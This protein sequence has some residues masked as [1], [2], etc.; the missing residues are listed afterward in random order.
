MTTLSRLAELGM[1]PQAVAARETLLGQSLAAL[2]NRTT[3]R[4]KPSGSSP[5]A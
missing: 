4:G 2:K 1:T 5:S 3:P